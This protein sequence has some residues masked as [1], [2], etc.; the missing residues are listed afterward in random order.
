LTPL[1]L[2]EFAQYDLNDNSTNVPGSTKDSLKKLSTKLSKYSRGHRGGWKEVR[3]KLK[4]MTS[5]SLLF[6]IVTYLGLS[7]YSDLKDLNFSVEVRI[8]KAHDK[9]SSPLSFDYAIL[10]ENPGFCVLVE[11]KRLSKLSNIEEYIHDFLKKIEE[12]EIPQIV[13]LR[14]LLHVHITPNLCSNKVD[15]DSIKRLLRGLSML[16]LEG[17][18]FLVTDGCIRDFK[19]FSDNLRALVDIVTSLRGTP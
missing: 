9:R 4:K 8:E 17:F 18:S 2:L 1:H 5:S 11:V 7:W 10:S 3:D 15:G 6:S 14:A 12:L 13:K 19:E 16:S